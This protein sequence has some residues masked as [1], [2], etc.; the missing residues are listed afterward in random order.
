MF[1]AAL[2]HMSNI[3][4]APRADGT[5]K[6]HILG[7]RYF[8]A[9]MTP[10]GR[11]IV[12]GNAVAWTMTIGMVSLVSVYA[13][14]AVVPDHNRIHF[15]QGNEN[16]DL[17]PTV[18]QQLAACPGLLH[19]PDHEGLSLAMSALQKGDVALFQTC[20]QV[21]GLLLVHPAYPRADCR[22]ARHYMTLSTLLLEHG[23]YY[24]DWTCFVF[25]CLLNPMNNHG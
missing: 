23:R 12:G 20:V 4:S 19:Q 16:R 10:D 13:D 2:S 11:T 22:T 8:H 21:S 17:R 18:Q 9:R 7:P 5:I 1:T 15:I 25:V 6:R 3:T 14:K 24:H